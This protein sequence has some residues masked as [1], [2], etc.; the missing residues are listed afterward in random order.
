MWKQAATEAAPA[1]SI[2]LTLLLGDPRL[3][4]CYSSGS[5]LA[6]FPGSP[7]LSL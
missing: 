6:P 2:Q 3:R 5:S 7:G 1:D 4:P